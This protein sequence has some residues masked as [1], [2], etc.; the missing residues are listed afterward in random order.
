M[1]AP[2]KLNTYEQLQKQEAESLARDAEWQA[3]MRA[4]AQRTID[5]MQAEEEQAARDAAN[6]NEAAFKADECAKY[7][8]AGGSQ[9]QFNQD[10]PRLRQQIVEQRFMGGESAPLSDSATAAK[11]HLDLLYR[12]E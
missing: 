3:E 5:A 9:I 4:K 7:I 1:N 10:W 12:R 8:R 2:K 11:R 6:E